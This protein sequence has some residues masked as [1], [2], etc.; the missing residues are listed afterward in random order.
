MATSKSKIEKLYDKPVAREKK[1]DAEA[2]VIRTARKRAKD[3]ATYWADNWKEA[4]ADLNFLAGDQ[5]PAGVKTQRELEQRPCITNNVLPTFV[6]QVLGDQRQNR[7]SIKVSAAKPAIIPEG[8]SKGQNLKISNEQGN[9]DYELGEVLTG[10]IK[11]IEYNCDAE[12]AY[13]IAFESAV[14]SGIGYLRVRTDYLADDTFEQDI[15]I[16]PINNQF[17]VTIDPA[18]KKRDRSDA[19]WC[20][21]DDMMDKEVF[22]EKYPEASTDPL[23]DGA[24][25]EGNSWFAEHAIKVSEYFTRE[26]VTRNIALLS[27]GRTVYMD[28]IEKIVDE[29]L[30]KG[31]SIVRERKVKTHKVYW[32]K[33]TGNEVLEGPIEIKCSTIPVIPVWGKT[34]T[35]KNDFI[36]RSIIRFSKDAQRMSNYW[37]SAATEN[38]ALAPKQPYVGAEGHVE[39]REQEW[40]TANTKN[41][42]ILTFVPQFQGDPGPRREQAAAMPAAEITMG[43]NSTDKIKA[44]IGIYDASIGAA[45]NETSGKAIIARQRQ[46]DRG[47][48]AFSD[49]LVKGIRRVGKILVEMIPNYYDTERVVRMKFED[50]TEDFVRLNEQVLDEQ[51]NTWVTVNDLSVAKYDVVVTTGPAFATQRIEAAE[52]MIQFA[53]AV[54][55]AAA[56][57]ADLIA[58]NMD[59]PGS[60]LI[61]ERLKKIVPPQVLTKEEREKLQE[62][63]PEQEPP[64]PEQQVQI[65]EFE[66]RG[67]EAEAKMALAQAKVEEASAD[68]VK[69]KADIVQA[70]L[71][72]AE[73]QAKLQQI[74]VGANAGNVDYQM[75]REMVAQ[76][77]AEAMQQNANVKP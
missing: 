2:E 42:A 18:A 62:D 66:A 36:T 7:P 76:A 50:G 31:V 48:F 35:I 46:G 5:W 61:A 27:D 26:Q 77:L 45:G 43:M 16:E 29:L 52:A 12:D 20:L 40:E 14:S 8:E 67:K 4:E 32:R 38:I 30:E 33:I 75:V 24:A 70:E 47:T 11:N 69:A 60:E 65:A 19:N 54:P 25:E 13:D 39:G 55:S 10:I 73:A 51:T 74:E 6:D 1:K 22:K 64:T 57:M 56:A 44:T 21:I 53:Q 3:G 72:T 68:V 63:A 9:Q 41:H 15:L 59:W 49:N 71:K 58:Q 23:P 17:S 37:E 28:E 34:L